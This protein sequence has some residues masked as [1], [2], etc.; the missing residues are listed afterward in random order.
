MKHV[1]NGIPSFLVPFHMTVTVF[2]ELPVEHDFQC[3]MRALHHYM[4]AYLCAL[5]KYI[6]DSS[7]Y[8]L[9]Q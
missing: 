1:L 8:S 2:K 7:K 4:V 3:K 5:L 6:P 9:G